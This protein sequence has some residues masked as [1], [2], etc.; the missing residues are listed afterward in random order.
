[1]KMSNIRSLTVSSRASIEPIDTTALR[2]HLRIQTTSEDALCAQY[3]KAARIALENKLSRSLIPTSYSMALDDF[4]DP[5]ILPYPPISSTSGDVLITY[6]NTTGGTSTCS[7]TVYTV[8]YNS[9]PGRI[10]LAYDASWPTDVRDVE[11]AITIAYKAGYTTA[12]CPE[13]AK[14]WL[15]HRAGVYYEHREPIIEGRS[16]TYIKRDFIDGLVDDLLVFSTSI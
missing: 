14:L 3:I 9:E 8:D 2:S 1:M 10:Y 12:T 6:V 15:Q 7:A 11:G 5:I 4:Y 16:L 13:N